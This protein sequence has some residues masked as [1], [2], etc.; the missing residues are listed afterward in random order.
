MYNDDTDLK[1]EVETMKLHATELLQRLLLWLK[2]GKNCHHCCLCCE[3]YA[4][5]KDS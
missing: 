5:C 4:M 3:Y 1:K 2:R